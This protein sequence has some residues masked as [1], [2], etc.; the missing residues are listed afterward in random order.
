[1]IASNLEISAAE[2]ES[3]FDAGGATVFDVR[4][5]SE[6]AM[7]HIPGALNGTALP[8][9]PMSEFTTDAAAILVAVNGDR[10]RPVV[11]Y[12]NGLY[13]EKSQRVSQELLE[14]GFTRVQR[15]QAG[16]P[17]WRASGRVT[18]IEN[19]GVAAVFVKDATAVWLD[20]RSPEEYEES[21]L[22]GSRYVTLNGMAAA[23]DDGRLPMH[24]HNTR[25]IV[26]GH[27]ASQARIMAQAVAHNAFH[28]V[29]FYP[30]NLTDLVKAIGQEPA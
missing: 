18:Q 27:S 15:Y 9:L 22:R 8:G 10:S 16:V 14:I 23:K 1:M 11:L 25:V 28:N 17:D 21:H 5:Y 24:D 12:C 20:A 29:S 30:G 3:A 2:L 6:Y 4:P 26:Y 19:L 13:C 7:G